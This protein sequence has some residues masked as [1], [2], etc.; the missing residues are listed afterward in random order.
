[1]PIVPT[2]ATI[3]KAAAVMNASKPP[4]S[5]LGLRG[6]T[7]HWVDRQAKASPAEMKAAL[8]RMI[9][10]EAAQHREMTPALQAR[11]ERLC[12][13]GLSHV[14]H[15]ESALSEVPAALV[16]LGQSLGSE[17]AGELLDAAIS[18]EAALAMLQG[19][20][21]QDGTLASP[22]Q[23]RTGLR[24]DTCSWLRQL[25]Q[26]GADLAG[27][28]TPRQLGLALVAAAASG[29]A[30]VL[31]ADNAPITSTFGPDISSFFAPDTL[32]A[33][34]LTEGALCGLA[35]GSTVNF[36]LQNVFVLY[37]LTKSTGNLNTLMMTP[38]QIAL[39]RGR[40]GRPERKVTPEFVRA[41]VHKLQHDR[42]ALVD[43]SFKIDVADLQH[44][45]RNQPE[46][47]AAALETILGQIH[48]GLKGDTQ[49]MMAIT[50]LMDLP[51]DTLEDARLRSRDADLVS[52][53]TPRTMNF[54]AGRD[55]AFVHAS[56][57]EDPRFQDWSAKASLLHLNANLRDD[58]DGSPQAKDPALADLPLLLKLEYFEFTSTQ[59]LP[60]DQAWPASIPSLPQGQ[61]GAAG[62]VQAVLMHLP[63][64]AQI[65]VKQRNRKAKAT[66][67]SQSV[68]PA[69]EQ[70]RRD[71]VRLNFHR[72]FV[73]KKKHH[74]PGR[75]QPKW[76]QRLCNPHRA[77]HQQAVEMQRDKRDRN[78]GWTPQREAA[79]FELQREAAAF[80]L[81][82]EAAAV[83]FKPGKAP[84]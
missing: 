47:A 84:A 42:L 49:W 83:E 14:G 50:L 22:E 68:P 70:G 27:S 23:R 51:Y 45:M 38:E 57:R 2:H 76:L 24:E 18:D 1:M 34:K 75:D 5:V 41:M 64:E 82:R 12:E 21:M 15:G 25:G 46:C 35:V 53:F 71:T 20:L 8:T 63:A 9:I 59:A 40:V 33:M 80:E 78:L 52:E 73:G 11:L 13:A 29:V 4:G 17:Q 6:S 55:P 16:H 81:Q 39:L 7:L 67:S 65:P 62:E 74:L 48:K 79:A 60:Y 66:P 54:T 43:L 56:L 44:A 77:G 19:K 26:S 31:A 10:N 61:A 36:A 69:A 3:T 37:K 32:A 72:W 30:G 28:L 58:Y